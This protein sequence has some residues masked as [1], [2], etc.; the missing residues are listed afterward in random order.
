MTKNGKEILDT[1]LI[2]YVCPI[3]GKPIEKDNVLLIN[4]ILTEKK[5]KE[6]KEMHNKAIV[7]SRFACD[8]CVNH[9]DDA[10]YIIEVD[11]E[12]SNSTQPYRTGRVIAVKKNFQLFVDHPEFIIHTG[13][14]VDFCFISNKVL[15]MIGFE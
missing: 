1:A 7:Y 11:E 2:Y 5:A 6:V 15:K 9:K 4:T 10:V 12:K 3:C 8:D 13:N 14:G